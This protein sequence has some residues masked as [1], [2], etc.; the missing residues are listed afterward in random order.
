[1]KNA[2]LNPMAAGLT[3]G[4]LWALALFVMTLV[5]ASNGYA[6]HI[7]EM[8]VGIYP[9]YELTTAGAFWGLLWGFLDGAIGGY[10][11]VWVYNMV[12]KKLG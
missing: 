8:L 11:M 7:F 3:M 12:A 2:Q 1:M 10:F 6:S 4:G 5:A 9:Y